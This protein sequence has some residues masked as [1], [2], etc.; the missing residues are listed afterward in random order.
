VIQKGLTEQYNVLKKLGNGASGNVVLSSNIKTKELVAVKGI[1]IDKLLKVDP[2]AELIK[3]EI[4]SHWD[5][6]D[7]EGIVKLLE[8]FVGRNNIYLVLEY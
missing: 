1:F 6:Q 7:C 4:Q 3:N 5:L 2:K 8:I